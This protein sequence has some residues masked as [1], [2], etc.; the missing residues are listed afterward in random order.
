MF[1]KGKQVFLRPTNTIPF[2]LGLFVGLMV[3][4]PD[5]IQNISITAISGGTFHVIK[6]VVSIYE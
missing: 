3:A 1:D 5:F 4:N 6:S 2:M